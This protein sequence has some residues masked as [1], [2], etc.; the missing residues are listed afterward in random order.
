M[1]VAMSTVGT[2]TLAPAEVVVP[3]TVSS[4]L[5]LLFELRNRL[6]QVASHQLRIPVDPTQRGLDTTYFFA[7]S[8]V[9]ANGICNPP[10]QDGAV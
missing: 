7:R 2:R 6:C 5:P 8:M 3:A 10:I 1:K 4:R 9:L